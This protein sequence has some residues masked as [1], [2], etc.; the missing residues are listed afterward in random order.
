MW[1]GSNDQGASVS[2]GIYLTKI[3]ANGFTKVRK[4]LMIK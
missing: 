1:D 3:H 4:M 2:T